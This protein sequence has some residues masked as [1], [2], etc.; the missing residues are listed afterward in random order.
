MIEV[1]NVEKWFE[2]DTEK[3]EVLK[4]VSF[5][6]QKGALAALCGV[7]GAGKS[8]LLNI[9]GGLDRPSSGKVCFGGVNMAGFSASKVARFRQNSIGFVFQFHHLLPDFSAVENVFMPGLIAG[10][11]K[12]GLQA[13][14]L[15]LL[16][17][18]GLDSRAKHFPAE[19]SGGERQRVAFARALFNE[20]DLVLADEPTGNLDTENARRQLELFLKANKQLGQTFLVATHNDTLAQALG[21]TLKLVDGRLEDSGKKSA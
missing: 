2:S 1:I 11:P 21:R 4:G 3:L 9:L 6:L 7:S 16:E 17:L 19:L 8:T 5:S 10:K 14:A 12:K 13:R 15:D 18:V 20:P